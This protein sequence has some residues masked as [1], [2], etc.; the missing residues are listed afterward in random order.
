M[1]AVIDTNVFV[2]ALIGPYT[3]SAGIMEMITSGQIVPIYDDRILFEYE[4]VLK[5]SKFS[6]PPDLVDHFIET[7][8]KLGR[9]T[10]PY[11]ANLQMKDEKDRS[12][13]EC[14]VATKAK[15]LITGNIKHFSKMIYSDINVYSPG[16]FLKRFRKE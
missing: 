16:D 14:T 6:F 11:Y 12:F 13:Y 2:S 8:K 9:R 5:R 3:V 4:M 15:V 7:I 1:E 10:V